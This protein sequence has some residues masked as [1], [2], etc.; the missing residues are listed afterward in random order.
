MFIASE[1]RLLK[2][3]KYDYLIIS[4]LEWKRLNLN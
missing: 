4:K 3:K 2:A 1:I